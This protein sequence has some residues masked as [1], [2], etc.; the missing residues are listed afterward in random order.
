[1]ERFTAGVIIRAGRGTGS[2]AQDETPL[3]V[4][5]LCRFDRGQRSQLYV[6]FIC[7]LSDDPACQEIFAG[8]HKLLVGIASDHHESH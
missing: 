1:M 4:L 6:Y 8:R 7:N 2:S 3:P 5:F